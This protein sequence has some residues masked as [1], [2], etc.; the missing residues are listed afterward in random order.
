MNTHGPETIQCLQCNKSFTRFDTL[1]RHWNDVR[2]PCTEPLTTKDK[3]AHTVTEA[4]WLSDVSELDEPADD[5]PIRKI[6]E[7][8]GR[9]QGKDLE[10]FGAKRARDA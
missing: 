5:D 8:K 4:R 9:L 1:Q 7:Q 10:R 3:E 6:F 2:T